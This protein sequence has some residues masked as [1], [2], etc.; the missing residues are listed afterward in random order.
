MF[1][2]IQCSWWMTAVCNCEIIARN[3]LLENCITWKLYYGS[4]HNIDIS[5][6]YTWN[7]F[8]PLF[9]RGEIKFTSWIRLAHD[10]VLSFCP[11]HKS[12]YFTM[13]VCNQ[14]QKG[15][16]SPVFLKVVVVFTFV[17][18]SCVKLIRT[19]LFIVI[20][21]VVTGWWINAFSPLTGNNLYKYGTG[22]VVLLLSYCLHS[23]NLS[24][25]PL[26][27]PLTLYFHLINM[28]S[29]IPQFSTFFAEILDL[30]V[31]SYQIIILHNSQFT[32]NQ[33]M[34]A[35]SFG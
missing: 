6:K 28:F 23:K 12:H 4:Y 34:Y 22:Y 13:P 30:C 35:T 2:S 19:S 20:Y 1:S 24:W 18:G 15:C 7:T 32:N 27:I 8:R 26:L 10:K 5:F 14:G 31:F 3:A 25:S 21:H 17:N 29:A 9:L 33:K 16:S 11:K